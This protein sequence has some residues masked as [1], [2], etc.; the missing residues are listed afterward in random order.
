[1]QTSNRSARRSRRAAMAASIVLGATVATGAVSAS[2]DD[3]EDSDID[4]AVVMPSAANDLAFSQS[5]IDSLDR[6]EE[7]EMID[8]YDFSE[9]LFV[10]EDAAAAIRGYAESGEY[11]LVIAHGSQYGGPLAEIAPDFPD[12]AFA[13]GTE[14]DT[15]GLPNVSAYSASSD[16]GGYVMGQMAAMLAGDG[17]IGVI[18]P[19]EVGDAKLYVDGFVAGAAATN[20]ELEVGVNYTDSFSDTALAAEAATSFVD[21]GATVLTGTAQMTVGAIGVA[22]ERG[23]LWF[24]TQSNQTQLAPEVVVA[25]QVY[26][27]EV[28]LTDLIEGIGGGTLG[29]ASYDINLANEGLVIE[30]NPD[31]DVPAD[32]MTAAEE[33]IAALA[34]GELET[35]VSAAAP[36]TTTAT[37]GTAAP[38]GTEAPAGT[39]APAGT[40]A[41]ASSAG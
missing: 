36:A 38:A 25:N 29:G 17:S 14:T 37:E 3:A 40:E 11:D 4:V 30:F 5:I 13:W 22:S 21:G 35:G 10:V 39:D 15:F 27:W 12:V 20:A 18:G 8:E 2:G 41:P 33:T 31:Y 32:V 6:L 19:I 28:V 23:V 16:Q 1:M 7:A 34:A 9:N 26:H 24:G